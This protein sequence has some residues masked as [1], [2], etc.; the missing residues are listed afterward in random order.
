MPLPKLVVPPSIEALRLQREALPEGSGLRT[1]LDELQVLLFNVELKYQIHLNSEN[2]SAELRQEF[3]NNE[4]PL[5]QNAILS[6]QKKDSEWWID[7]KD[8]ERMYI[9]RK[10]AAKKRVG[11]TSM[12]RLMYNQCRIRSQTDKFKFSSTDNCEE[13]EVRPE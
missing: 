9:V 5:S 6:I 1:F 11:S 7:D 12:N 13:M 2:I 8:N 10:E 4:I 3:K